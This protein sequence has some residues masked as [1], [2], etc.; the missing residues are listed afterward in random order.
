MCK[1]LR[2]P[3]ITIFLKL[4][5]FL[6]A[7]NTWVDRK[8]TDCHFITYPQHGQMSMFWTLIFLNLIRWIQLCI[9]KNLGFVDCWD[10]FIIK[11]VLKNV[12]KLA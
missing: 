5:G 2:K 4:R 9:K 12:I 10:K 1:C 8:S 7:I 3:Y 11:L 6:P